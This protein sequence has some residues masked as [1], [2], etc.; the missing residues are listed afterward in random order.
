MTWNHLA[1]TFP[2]CIIKESLAF[3]RKDQTSAGSCQEWVYRLVSMTASICNQCVRERMYPWKP[4]LLPSIKKDNREKK[5]E[6][7]SELFNLYLMCSLHMII[8]GKSPA[9][10]TYE[11]VTW[12][13]V[14]N[15]CFTES[16]LW[17]I[18]NIL[19]STFKNHNRRWTNK[20]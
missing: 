5:K 8:M 2:K 17:S 9:Q 3:K 12:Y 19:V 4:T 11:K 16:T 18:Y 14:K 6:K 13:L 10:Q 15:P 7:P 1:P 20:N